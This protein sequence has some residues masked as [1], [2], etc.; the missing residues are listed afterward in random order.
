MTRTWKPEPK[1]HQD[2]MQLSSIENCVSELVGCNLVHLILWK[3]YISLINRF[4][5]AVSVQPKVSFYCYNTI[6]RRGGHFFQ[7]FQFYFNQT[8]I[9]PFSGQ[10]NQCNGPSSINYLHEIPYRMHRKTI[11]K[12]FFPNFC[13]KPNQCYFVSNIFFQLYLFS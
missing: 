1:S 4:I 8:I 3:L 13:L 7:C 12:V 5:K 6:K 11:S 9:F 10:C 2:N